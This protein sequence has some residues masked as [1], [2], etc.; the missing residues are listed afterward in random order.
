MNRDCLIR[1]YSFP[2]CEG[3]DPAK[4]VKQLR[5]LIIKSEY[6]LDISMGSFYILL[7]VI[8]A[9]FTPLFH[10]DLPL[11]SRLLLC[12]FAAFAYF[13]G[14]DAAAARSIYLYHLSVIQPEAVS[15]D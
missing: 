5:F 4:A 10:M 9:S 12:G 8:A 11:P 3:G 7:C 6:Q 15:N 1:I 2:S 14:Y 13:V